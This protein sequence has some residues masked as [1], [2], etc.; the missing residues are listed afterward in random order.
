MS[1]PATLPAK[2]FGISHKVPYAI[3]VFLVCNFAEVH[4]IMTV[5]STFAVIVILFTHSGSPFIVLLSDFSMPE[6]FS[7]AFAFLAILR[8][9]I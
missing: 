5:F 8:G 1:C 4:L 2:K 6:Y 9:V 3:N 7:S